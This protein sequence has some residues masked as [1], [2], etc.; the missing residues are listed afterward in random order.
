M[1][2][3]PIS[4]TRA[5]VTALAF[6]PDGQTLYVGDE[7]GFVIAWD[8]PTKTSRDLRRSAHG[9]YNLWPLAD[10]SR[11]LVQDRGH[12]YNALESDSKPLL[13]S[14]FRHVT[15]DGRALSIG[16][17]A[18]A[19]LWDI[20]SGQLIPL[21]G[22]L[23]KTTNITF[24]RF[25]PDG[26]TL[27]TYCS[28]SNDLTLWDTRNG[29]IVGTLAPSG[30]GIRAAELSADGNMFAVGRQSSLWVYDVP[31]R[32]LRHLLTFTKEFRFLAFHPNGRLLAS[33]ATDSVVTLWDT[34]VGQQL[35]QYE[36][37]TGQVMSLAF[38]PDGLTCAAGGFGKFV[39][40]DVDV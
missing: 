1:W 13:M 2:L 23:G 21:P 5:S 9:V 22:Q 32:Q 8:L 30:S 20:E 34:E 24:H 15:P 33:A 11:L 3:Q 12:L 31:S 40:F 28:Q 17:R 14:D 27:L 35:K 18:L 26:V 4:S 7:K 38:A 36:W 37:Q 6:S 25:L 39:V 10:G 29:E 16:V 19:R